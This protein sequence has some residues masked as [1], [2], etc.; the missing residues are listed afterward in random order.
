MIRLVIVGA[1]GAHALGSTVEVELE[2]A[3]QLFARGLAVPFAQYQ[4]RRH[5]PQAMAIARNE[6]TQAQVGNGTRVNKRPGIRA[7]NTR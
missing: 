6:Q 2:E 7:V 5:R 1:G 4:S 3:E